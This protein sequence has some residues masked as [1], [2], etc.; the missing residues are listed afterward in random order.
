MS[1]VLLIL[2]V[3]GAVVVVNVVLENT[4]PMTVTLFGQ[5]LTGLN[6][7]EWLAVAAG[8]GFL[9]MLLLSL[10]VAV[11][12]RRRARRHDLRGTDDLAD[13]VADLER[14]NYSLRQSLTPAADTAQREPAQMSG[15]NKNR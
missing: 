1:V 9:V 12:G 15:E 13:R 11:S 4:A 2:A 14:E 3:L 7:G 5:E 6:D 8:L 10:A